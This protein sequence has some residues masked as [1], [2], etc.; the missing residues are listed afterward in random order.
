MQRLLIAFVLDAYWT[1]NQLNT[2]A[3]RRK[4]YQEGQF[5]KTI[6]RSYINIC[7]DEG[8]SFDLFDKERPFMQATYDKDLDEGKGTSVSKLI[9][10]LPRDNTPVHFEHC[11]YGELAVEPSKCLS[12]LLASYCFSVAMVQLYLVCLGSWDISGHA[13]NGNVCAVD[14]FADRDNPAFETLSRLADGRKPEDW[15]I[16]QGSRLCLY[17]G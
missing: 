8:V 11:E 2:V 15:F 1:N 3:D 6:L 17:P 10:R 13:Q 5:D 14:Y 9:I 12:A 16:L 7:A 4:L